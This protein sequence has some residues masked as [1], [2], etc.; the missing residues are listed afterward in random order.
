MARALSLGK[1]TKITITLA[2]AVVIAFAGW[3]ARDYI[4]PPSQ[5]DREVAAASED[6]SR[7]ELVNWMIEVSG[8]IGGFDARLKALEDSNKELKEEIKRATWRM[9][10]NKR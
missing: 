5:G 7:R 2:T 4:K 1:E 9:E 3:T 10:R 6:P 8:K